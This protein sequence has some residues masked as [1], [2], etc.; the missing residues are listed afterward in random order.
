MVSDGSAYRE[1]LGRYF[2]IPGIGWLP[3]RTRRKVDITRTDL[4]Y[5]ERLYFV[6]DTI[7]IDERFVEPWTNERGISGQ[8]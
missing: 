2:E 8:I 5:E 6:H 3:E 1:Y 7:E 4:P